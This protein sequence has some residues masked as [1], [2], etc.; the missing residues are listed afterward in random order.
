MAETLIGQLR[1][2]PVSYLN[3]DGGWSPGQGVLLE[4]DTP[5]V[6]IKDLFSFGGLLPPEPAGP[7]GP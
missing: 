4:H 1:A 2:D 7:A 6:T 5:I 3:Q